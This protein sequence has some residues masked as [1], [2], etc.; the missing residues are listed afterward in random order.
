METFFDVM[1]GD[2]RD[3]EILIPLLKQADCIIP[4]G[5]IGRRSA[6]QQR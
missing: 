1:R 2:A 3:E 6:L 4:F 5:G